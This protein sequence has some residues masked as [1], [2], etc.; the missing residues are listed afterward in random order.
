MCTCSVQMC[1]HVCGQHSCGGQRA[2]SELSFENHL[3]C[4]ETQSLAGLDLTEYT[5]MPGSEPRGPHLLPSAGMTSTASTSTS[6][7]IWVQRF[8]G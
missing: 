7:A 1:G 6:F 3:P 2:A 5:R 8:S 4:F